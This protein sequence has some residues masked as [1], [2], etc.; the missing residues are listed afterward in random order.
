MSYDLSLRCYSFPVAAADATAQYLFGKVNS[1]GQFAIL[2][3]STQAADGV[4]Q[5]D[6][7]STGFVGQI[8]FTGISKVVV[9]AAG[10]TVGDQVMSDTSGKATTQTSTNFGQ[11]R[12]L[13][14]GV[15]G[16]IVPVL[17]KLRNEN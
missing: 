13:F 5:D 17:L 1:N 7:T 6:P 16:D 3:A 12:C 11:G 9:G 15:S 14:T 8:G 10:V 4:L 2:T